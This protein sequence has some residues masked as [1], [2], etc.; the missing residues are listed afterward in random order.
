[1]SLHPPTGQSWL[2]LFSQ[3]RFIQ[4]SILVQRG[5]L[6]AAIKAL[7]LSVASSA[8]GV[9]LVA[10]TNEGTV[11]T[12]VDSGATWVMRPLTGLFVTSVA[13]SD[14]GVKLVAA[15][16]DGQLHI[17]SDSGVT[18]TAKESSRKW[19]AV[20]SSSNGTALAGCGRWWPNLR[21]Y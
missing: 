7:L 2:Q 18:W 14:D 17:S 19:W 5:S 3:V 16:Y 4:A 1:M 12:S 20:T 13:S 6:E 11:Y 10:S 8:D 21:Q 9:K 15:V